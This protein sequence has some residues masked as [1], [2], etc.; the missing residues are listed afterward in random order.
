MRKLSN[1]K[2]TNI[3][4]DSIKKSRVLSY[5]H[6][7]DF[8][9]EIYKIIPLLFIVGLLP[10]VIRLK[11]IPLEGPFYE[12]WNG[13]K[14]NA[15]FF[16]YYK[17]IFIY[18]VTC[19][20]MLNT[21]LFTKKIKFTKA[22]YFMGTYAILII[23]STVF[24]KYPQ[25]TLNGFVERRE[26]M[27]IVLCYLLLMFS[28][29][30]LVETEKQIKAIIY[31]LGISGVIISIISIFQYFGM[32]IFA[33]EFAK[34]YMISKEIQ[35]QIKEFNIQFGEKYSYG[36]FYNPNYLGG[37]IS[38]YAPLMLSF[39]IISK[40]IKEKIIFSIFF[41]LSILALYGSR[42][43]AGVLGTIGTVLLLILVVIARYIIKDK[44]QEEYK[45]IMFAKFAPILGVLIILPVS[46]SYIPISQ[47]PLTRIRTEA[48]ALFKP[49]DLKSKDYKEIGPINDI[50]QIDDKMIE[51][52]IN[53]SSTY[54]KIDDSS[55]INI[56][57]EDKVV[58]NKN[59]DD[60]IDGE[61]YILDS[62]ESYQA[63]LLL[64][65][66]EYSDVYGIKYSANPYGVDLY[67]IFDKGKL[68]IA[69]SFYKKLD[70][71][72]DLQPSKHIGFTG[73]GMIASGRGY[74]WS[75]SFPIM[76][77]NLLIGT[78]QDSFVIEFPRNDIYGRQVD[79]HLTRLWII[80]DK[81]HSFYIQVGVQSGVLSLIVI[82]IGIFLLL[83]RN[84][85]DTF[86]SDVKYNWNIMSL[87]IVGYLISSV[88][89][90]SILAI[91][92]IIYIFIGICISL[93]IKN[94]KERIL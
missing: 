80:T 50:K 3:K 68:N 13:E 33:T 35:A 26:G 69:D 48:V 10:F 19:W 84:I 62:H 45:K 87:G 71:N 73:K 91:S 21:F 58:W 44:P 39:A 34:D 51:I 22:Y 30:N 56:L 94:S 66:T 52:V 23:L 60:L 12:F 38:F 57:E 55:N 18:I 65:K 79:D 70:I 78:G 2:D 25:I 28:T 9:Y 27:W 83:Y 7:G 46:L 93:T 92:P 75:R 36:V 89:N 32:D 88:F 54:I 16:T 49:S 31:T 61:I 40:N 20:A 24:S 74:I 59:I 81:P 47:N 42:S 77:E 82:L 5:R 43:E 76:L 90:D 86:F 85:Q 63:Q 67:F 8:Y 41:I 72:R 29:I 64:N 14:I 37:Y 17:Q 4:K 53:Q 6:N 11:I 15:D 1:S